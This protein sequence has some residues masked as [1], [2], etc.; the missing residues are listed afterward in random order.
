MEAQKMRNLKEMIWIEFRKAA[1]SKVPLWTIL[2]SLFM[3]LGIAL[4]IF[5]AR[6]P[7]ISQ[8]LGLLS[9]KA[10]LVAYS[11]TDWPAYLGLT[12]MIIAA[13]GFFIFVLA[14]SWIFGRE[15]AD[16][17]VKDL[18][19]VPVQRT[20]ILFAKFTVAVLWSMA[21]TLAITLTSL[22]MGVLLQLPGGSAA[23]IISKLGLIAASAGLAIIVALPFAFIASIGRGYLLP[24]GLVVLLLM[25]TN[26][27]A[28][29]GQGDY[30]P[31]AVPGLLAQGKITALPI[32]LIIVFLT[33]AAGMYIT[34]LWWKYAD[35][36]K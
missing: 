35:Q 1:R 32:S 22:L 11:A 2:G 13:G 18:L 28:M 34:Y 21:V 36:N 12:A 23:V 33:G 16:G 6:N 31:W 27:I 19:A 4:L 24:L 14:T 30:F 25:M 9:V 5:I 7:V 17:T 26:L 3:P 15:F 10:D 8:K 29:T 20:S